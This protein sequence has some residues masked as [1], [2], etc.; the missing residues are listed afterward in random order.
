MSQM[1]ANLPA[2]HKAERR[3]RLQDESK[4]FVKMGIEIRKT[5]EK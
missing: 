5:I 4:I 2:T 1:H 3:R